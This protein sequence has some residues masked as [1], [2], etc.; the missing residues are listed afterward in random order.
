MAKQVTEESGRSTLVLSFLIADVR[1]YTRFT[2]ERGDAAAALLAKRF[3]D[4]ARDAVEARGGRVIELRGDEALA[5]FESPSQA[6]RAAVEFQATCA[7]E[8]E[9]DPAFPLPV[10]IGIDSGEAVPVEDGYRGVALNTAARLCSNAGAGQVLVT[11][12]IV[13]STEATDAGITFVERGPAS[14]KG[15]EQ[16]VDVIEAVASQTS[17]A[18]PQVSPTLEWTKDQ[19]RGIP[20]ELDPLTPLVDREHEMRWLRGTWRMVRRGGGRVL[21]VSGPAQIGKTRLAGE[22]AAHVHADGGAIRHAG[23]GGAA[24]AMTLSAIRGAREASTST[25]LVLDDVDV[26]GPQVAE[27]LE[28]SL[29][30]LSARPVLVLGLLRDR[31]AVADLARLIERV[32]GRGDGHRG[33][34]PFDIDG[35]RGIVRLYVGQDETDAPVESMARASQGIPGRIHEV[36]SEWARSEASR[37][38]AAAAEFLAAGRDRHASDL[39]FANNVIGLKLGRLY[40]VEGRDVLAVETCPYKGLAAF[41][42]EDSDYFFGRERLVGELAARTVRVGLLGVVGA[43]GSGKSSVIGAGL[44]P[45]LGAGLLPGSENWKQVAIRPGEHPMN[46]LRAALSSGAEDPL[47]AAVEALTPEGRLVLVVDQFEETFTLCDDEAERSYFVAALTGAAKRWPENVAVILAIRADYYG[48]CAPY[49]DLA[50]ALAAN[51]VLVGPLTREELKRAIELP[52]R[53]AGLR[54]E[55]ALAD[56]LVE[57][58]SDEPGGLPLLSTALVELWQTREDGWIRMEAHEQTGGVR[59]AVSRL[60]ETSYEQLSPVEQEAARRVFLRLVASGEGETVTRRRVE[61]D[62][63]DPVHDQDAAAVLT[64]LTQDRLLTKTEDMVEVAHEALLREWP[65][66]RAWLEEDVQGHQLRQHLTHAARQW[67]ETGRE[68]S[69]VYRGARLSAALDWAA[70]G[71]PDLN[72]LERDFL[73][74]S[75]QA[76]E[77][78]AERQRRTNRRLRGLLVGTAVFLVVA[79]VAGGL[80]LVQRGHA[81]DEAERAERQARV[82]SARELAAAAAANLDVDSELS[83]LL[84]LEAVDA[85]WEAYGTVVPEAEEILHRAVERSRAVLTVAQGG[86][87]AVSADGT[88]FGTTG[89]NG[90]AIVWDT[91]GGERLLTLQG[92]R[93]AVNGIAFSPDGSRLATTGTDGTV[94]VWQ[95]ASGRQLS[96]SRG[97]GDVVWSPEFSPD[98]KWL[99]TIDD[100]ATVRIWDVA[101]GREDMTLAGPQGTR[102]ECLIPGLVFSPDGTRL[103]ASSTSDGSAQIW[104]L[105]TGKNAVTLAGHRLEVTQMAFS[106]DS[107]GIATASLHGTARIWDAM[108]GKPLTT[109]SGHPGDVLAVAYSPDGTR[110]ATGGSDAT[111][112]VWDASTGDQLLI[113][114]GHTAGVEHVAFT[115]DGDRLL[116]GGAD[117]T[118]RLWDVSVEGGRDWLTVPG[119][120]DRLGAVAFSP[121]GTMFAVPGQL[122]GVT[123][124]DV[125]TGEEMITLGGHDA[126]IARL[127]FSPDGT[128]LAGAA[129]SGETISRANWSVPIWDVNTGKV[130]LTLTG[131]GDEVSSVAFSPDGRR[132]VTGS[133][134]HTVRVWDATTGRQLGSVKARS[135]AYAVGF[136]PDGRYLV[137]GDDDGVVTVWDAETLERVRKLKGPGSWIQDVAFGPSGQAVTPSGDGTA[138]IWDLESGRE[139]MT[140]R[141][142][143]GAVYDAAFSSDGARVATASDDGTAKLWDPSTGRA[144]LTLFGHDRIINSLAFSPDGR[145]LATVNGD[146]TV[147]LH[148]LPIGEFRELARERVTRPLT[149]E[150]CQ[151]Y[152]H[153]GKCP[154]A[155]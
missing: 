41:E 12:T 134:D 124:R 91:D 136:S 140:L 55:S 96:V 115:P 66:L 74:E 154:A 58:V 7:E 151:R 83:V 19:E 43:S 79:L 22:I 73:S 14:F 57:E 11:R 148:L 108:S 95:G 110:I 137:T 87:L 82:A 155:I 46:G 105:A 142:H 39:E 52:A 111:A 106:P 100:D 86:G 132:L 65:R 133:W 31:T 53:R 28:A 23:P 107:K 48:H 99:A 59:G 150:E 127:A 36:V 63:F 10:G 67:E 114:A 5:V 18:P 84:A 37:R 32:D 49:P 25:L 17:A 152:L 145:L 104:N 13:G 38:L 29:E 92:H 30:V 153:V 113:L 20:A 60:A 61:L 51:H 123:I 122:R 68:A 81:R 101:T 98:G 135:S 35:V 47:E 33:L 2:A 129:G 16:P 138:R 141:G 4:L 72:E 62:E 3:A 15:F 121:D 45:S 143:S 102:C 94:R 120:H 117:G 78:E 26:A 42:R 93:G 112:R 125:D 130:V 144:V 128:K 118:T 109:F 80:A 54:V 40:S 116:T 89:R 27:E 24:T 149:D 77:R 44:L 56:A 103:A 6:V 9:A 85:T 71:E 50:E 64:R 69:E 1:G 139:V 70:T 88:R 76:S 119:P 75:R 34:A 21:F 131:H 146:G 147:S 97:D 8:S 90:T 126:T